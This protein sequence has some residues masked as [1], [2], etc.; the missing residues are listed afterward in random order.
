MSLGGLIFGGAYTWRAYF[1]N[2]TVVS[3]LLLFKVNKKVKMM[4]NSS[5][6]RR[7]ISF[8]L[9]LSFARFCVISLITT[10]QFDLV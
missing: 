6:R 2:S 4:Y 8:S 1:R 3:I 7:C 10:V 9:L 5:E